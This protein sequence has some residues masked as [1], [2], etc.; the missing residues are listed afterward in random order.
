MNKEIIEILEQY[1]FEHIPEKQAVNELLGLF[2]VIKWVA[3]DFMNLESRPPK[4]GKYLVVRKDGKTHW[5]TWNGS[6]WAYNEKAIRYWAV[7][8]PPCL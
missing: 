2:S 3:Y 8:Q 6:G 1:K 4:Y 7:I 5:E